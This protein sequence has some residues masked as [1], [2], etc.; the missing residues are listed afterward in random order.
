M[1]LEFF[2]SK[3]L[4]FYLARLFFV[5]ILAVLVMLV[6]VL[7]MLDL[8]SKTGDI[9]AAPGNGQ[10]ELLR[11]ASLRVPQQSTPRIRE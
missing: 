1:Q 11:Y 6:L 5:R 2:P 3:T 8:L 10:A 9:L 4:T 7:M